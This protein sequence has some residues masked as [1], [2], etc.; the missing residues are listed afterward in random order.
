MA[1]KRVTVLIAEDHPLFRQGLA[2]TI[3]L[4]PELELVAEAGDGRTALDAIRA[5]APDVAVLDIKMPLLD[6]MRV[7]RAVARDGLSTRVLFVSAFCG[8]D[9]VHDALSIGA[10]GFISKESSAK[11]ICEAI[12]IV[13][14]GETALAPEM[15]SALAGE[16]RLRATHDGPRLSDREAEILRLVADGLSAAEIADQLVVSVTTVKTHLRNLYEKLGVSD[17]AAAVA[18]AMR[19]GVLE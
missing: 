3:R 12:R 10:G 9:L 18:S 16:L 4:R 2:D 11:Q 19:H 14:R 8:G 1:L 13:A 17:R 7:L 5:Q 6:G 15:Q